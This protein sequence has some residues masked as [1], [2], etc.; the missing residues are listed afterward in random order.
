MNGAQG[1]P[2]EHLAPE[3]FRK[4][5]TSCKCN[6]SNQSH[7]FAEN[8]P[9]L[10]RAVSCLFSFWMKYLSIGSNQTTNSFAVGFV[11]CQDF[12]SEMSKWGLKLGVFLCNSLMT[13][14]CGML[15]YSP[16]W[17][18]SFP[19]PPPPPHICLLPV[20][21]SCFSLWRFTE[22]FVYYF[23]FPLPSCS[24]VLVWIKAFL[25]AGSLLKSVGSSGSLC[26]SGVLL[27][28]FGFS[29]WWHL[30]FFLM[31]ETTVRFGLNCAFL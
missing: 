7:L 16:L 6:P 22:L 1:A 25:W 3:Q 5:E 28:T 4:V 21:P 20:I 30:G 31:N 23:W 15:L 10:L 29:L 13:N 24:A 27:P 11:F 9:V 12:F 18:S 26:F 19:S 14:I 17:V 8:Q 2:C